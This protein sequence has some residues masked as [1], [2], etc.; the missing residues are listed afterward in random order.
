MEILS[1]QSETIMHKF[2][3]CFYWL[4]SSVFH[5]EIECYYLIEIGDVKN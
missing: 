5:Q 2:L 3:R 1:Q 4:S